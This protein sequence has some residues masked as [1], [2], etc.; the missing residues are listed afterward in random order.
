MQLNILNLF[1]A[2]IVIFIDVPNMSNDSL[3]KL[4]PESVWLS[5]AVFKSFFAFWWEKV[6]QVH[7]VH[8]SKDPW[9]LLVASGL[10]RPQCGHQRSALLRG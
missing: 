5:L 4:A 10:W 9:K 6:T 2:T 8:F 3:F 7:P 1:L